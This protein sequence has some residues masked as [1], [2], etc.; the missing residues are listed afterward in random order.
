MDFR[1]FDDA[2][3]V[4]AYAARTVAGV[5]RMD[6][7]ARIALPTGK[8]PLMLYERLA[9]VH[10]AGSPDLSG[11]Q[12]FALDEFLSPT[13]ARESSFAHVLAEKLIRPARLAV[14]SLHAMNAAAKDAAAEGRRYETAIEALGGLSLAILGI[15]ANGHIAFNEPGTPFGSRTGLRIL[16]PQSRAANAYLFPGK[17]PDAVPSTALS[18]GIATI[19]AAHTVLLLATGAGKRDVL[20][21]L[22]NEPP[23]VGLPAS[24]LTDHPDCIVAM[25]RDAAG[26]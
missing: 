13:L 20:T 7:M 2:S 22:R 18:M 24:A 19:L 8:T 5:V 12:W 14:S 16:T 3:G 11:V 1:V 15:G 21:R 4:A 10:R 25:D 23:G 9:A 26:E 17:G 6:P